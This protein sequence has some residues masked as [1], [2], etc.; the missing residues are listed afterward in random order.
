M[1][2]KHGEEKVVLEVQGDKNNAVKKVA[3]PASNTSKVATLAD[4]ISAKEREKLES[5]K[6]KLSN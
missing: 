5:L 3:N 6:K 4:L 1:S 2:T